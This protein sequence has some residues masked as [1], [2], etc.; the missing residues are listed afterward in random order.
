MCV[1]CIFLNPD[2]NRGCFG[3]FFH[4][5][6]AFLAMVLKHILLRLA[7]VEILDAQYV[8]DEILAFKSFS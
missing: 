6:E 8:F 4:L 5:K 2:T 1:V 7:A 3:I